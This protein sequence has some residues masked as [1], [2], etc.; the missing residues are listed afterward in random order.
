MDLEIN[1][2]REVL[3]SGG[4]ILYPTDTLPGLGCDANNAEAVEKIVQIKG[5]TSDK[6]FVILLDDD[7]KLHNYLNTVPDVAWDILDHNQE[8]LTIIYPGGKNVAPAVLAKD[9]SL[10]IRIT[11]DSFC[12]ALIRKFGRAIVST[13]ANK[14]GAPA[15]KTIS[16]VDELIQEQV[17]HI[18]NL[19]RSENAQKNPSKIIKLELNG[20]VRIIRN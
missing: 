3:K 12:Q 11:K 7:R 19:P 15:P 6:G 20:E 9:G 13:S 10:A 5:R 4:T 2:A 16:N 18:V 8:P 14:S 17:D 1:K